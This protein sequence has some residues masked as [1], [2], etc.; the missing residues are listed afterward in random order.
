MTAIIIAFHFSSFVVTS[1]ASAVNGSLL[2]IA[3]DNN[4]YSF[5]NIQYTRFSSE[6]F[7]SIHKVEMREVISVS[8]LVFS[9]MLQKWFGNETEPQTIY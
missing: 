4:S 8:R 5:Q 6:D 9:S 3:I 2:D 7:I 1:R